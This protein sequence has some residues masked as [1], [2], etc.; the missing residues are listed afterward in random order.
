MDYLQNLKPEVRALR[1]YALRP[2]QADV[3]LNQNENPWDAP[4]DFKAAVTKRLAAINWGRYPDFAPQNLPEKLAAYAGW[5]PEGVLVGNG[6]NELI[7]A[8]L[9]VTMRPGAKVLLSE[10]TFALYRQIAAVQGGEVLSVPPLEDFRYDLPALLKAVQT[11]A[12]EVMI[13]CSPN[14]PTGRVLPLAELAELLETAKGLVAVD[15][16]YIEFGGVSAVSL[17]SRYPHLV[18]LRTFS[19]AFGLAAW[20]VGY[21]LARQELV[22]EIG[23]ALLPYNVN[24]FS[25]T[26]AEIAL[27]NYE[28]ERRA[29]VSTIL[30]ERAR[31]FDEIGRVKGLAAI[32][33]E[34]NFL[35]VKSEKPP[36]EIFA[37]TL[38]RGVLIRDVSAYPL[39]SQ[40]FR[41]S[42]GTPAENDKLLEALR[43]V[44]GANSEQERLICYAGT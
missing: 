42:I 34:A 25:Q 44:A 9:T 36:A 7:Q 29:Q 37:E 11:Y 33:S 13:I 30:N 43:E 32:P 5:R 41:V 17:L 19:K 39:L 12:P 4:A 35:L 15:E 23:K 28:S 24:I 2:A 27:E 1:A 6:S 18:V 8:L 3:K 20:R 40:Y 22:R 38:R 16:A 21:L 26:V 10:P 31:V 14:N